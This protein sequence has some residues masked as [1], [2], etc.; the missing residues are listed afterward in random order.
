MFL[1]RDVRRCTFIGPA[2]PRWANSDTATF[3]SFA[4]AAIAAPSVRNSPSQ[5]CTPF[6]GRRT[7][8]CPFRHG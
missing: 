1:N 3:K 5:R 7:S 6:T 2:R 4:N 8:N